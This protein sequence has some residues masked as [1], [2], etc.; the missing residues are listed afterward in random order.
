[1]KNNNVN[2]VLLVSVAL[3]VAIVASVISAGITGNV[4]KQSNNPVGKFKVYTKAEI[5]TAMNKISARI[6]GLA[7]SSDSSGKVYVLRATGF[8]TENNV[9][10]VSIAMKKNNEWVTVTKDATI[11]KTVVV[12]NAEFMID[13]IDRIGKSVTMHSTNT[14]AYMLNGEKLTFDA[15][16]DEF[17]FVGETSQ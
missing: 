7:N 3:I 1:M 16:T 2:W 11:G 17:F 13:S 12:N 8:I 4:I 15:D 9:S 5:D 10:K 14:Y 6:D